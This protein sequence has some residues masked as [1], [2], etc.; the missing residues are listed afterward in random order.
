MLYIFEMPILSSNHICKKL[1]DSN[2]RI[3]TIGFYKSP[4]SRDLEMQGTQKSM[5]FAKT[6]R[7]LQF[8]FRYPDL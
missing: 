7:F 4:T 6:I 8:V 3:E 1:E 5:K 2:F